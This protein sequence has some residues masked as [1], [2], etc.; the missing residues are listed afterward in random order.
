MA[1]GGAASAPGRRPTADD[2][3][4]AQRGDGAAKP[5][6]AAAAARWRTAAFCLAALGCVAAALALGAALGARFGPLRHRGGA[7]EPPPPPG[8][9]DNALAVLSAGLCLIGYAPGAPPPIL[10]LLA[11]ALAAHLSVVP[12]RVAA[13]AAFPDAAACIDP[14][15]RAPALA[16]ALSIAAPTAAAL[17]PLAVALGALGADGATDAARSIVRALRAAGGTPARELRL[18][19]L[20]PPPGLPAATTAALRAAGGAFASVNAVPA[21]APPEAVAAPPAP[22][23]APMPAPMPPPHVRPTHRFGWR[24]ASGWPRRAEAAPARA[25][26]APAP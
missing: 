1:A 12:L 14:T 2:G 15:T 24:M 7:C 20:T 23:P 8:D 4:T 5:R 19:S 25:A 13:A 10:Q 18:L 26:A 22:A 21:P 17:P 3:A 6:A 16:V 11:R 9:A